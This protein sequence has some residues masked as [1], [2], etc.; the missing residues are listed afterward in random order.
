M[1]WVICHFV[2]GQNQLGHSSAKKFTTCMRTKHSIERCAATL[3]LVLPSDI[4]NNNI[5]PFLELPSFTFTFE[6]EVD[7]QEEEE[8]ERGDDDAESH[9]DLTMVHII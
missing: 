2:I 4:V 8:G 9:S 1:G 3:E 6:E 5:L 7:D